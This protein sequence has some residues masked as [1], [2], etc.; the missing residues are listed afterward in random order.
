MIYFGDMSNKSDSKSTY[1][2]LEKTQMTSIPDGE[3]KNTMPLSRK[4]LLKEIKIEKRAQL[5]VHGIKPE[6]ITKELRKADFIIGR[7]AEGDLQIPVDDVSR[8]HAR[9]FFRNE[10]YYIE[11]L[12]STNGT[13]VNG[14]TVA[15][16]VLRNNDQI[17]IGDVRMIFV[18]IETRD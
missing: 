7:S 11:D 14:I 2:D 4:A 13:Y 3:L 16:C 8:N 6:P 12:G 17:E 1:S 15:K 18:E 5:E 9:I 10:E